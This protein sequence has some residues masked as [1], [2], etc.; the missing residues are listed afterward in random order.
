MMSR[1]PLTPQISAA[2]FEACYWMKEELVAFCRAEGLPTTGGKQ[3]LAARIRDYLEYQPAAPA[4]C[5]PK[6]RGKMPA[7][8]TRATVIDASFRCS[9]ELRRFFE[10]EIGSSF[11]FDGF[12]RDLVKNGQGMT[13]DQAITAWREHQQAPKEESE[14]GAQFEYNRHMRQF[15]KDHPGKTFQEAVAAWKEKK[16]LR[17]RRGSGGEPGAHGCLYHV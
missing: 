16:A 5:A 11:H 17:N 3:E 15:F 12:M 1:P 2:D 13:L 8:L 10:A 6:P 4:S 14:I 9:Q 7:V